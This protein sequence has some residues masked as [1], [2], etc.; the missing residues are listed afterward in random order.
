LLF[1]QK[2]NSVPQYLFRTKSLFFSEEL[3]R[4]L[5]VFWR[6][7][8]VLHFFLMKSWGTWLFSEEIMRCLMFL[9][10]N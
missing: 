1:L 8:E 10:K 3:M 9:L 6:N 5:M 7:N 4:R 2:T